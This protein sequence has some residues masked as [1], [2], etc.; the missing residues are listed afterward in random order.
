MHER[1]S[2]PGFIL[3]NSSSCGIFDTFSHSIINISSD[4]TCVRLTEELIALIILLYPFVSFL[5]KYSN[6]IL[7][8][9]FSLSSLVSYHVILSFSFN[10]SLFSFIHSLL[11]FFPPFS[12]PFTLMLLN[13]TIHICVNFCI[14]FSFPPFQS[15][16]YS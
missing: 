15:V 6:G 9:P 13:F 14:L 16:L 4:S 7:T 10:I 1:V 8:P 2:W 11:S 3:S 12:P 5:R